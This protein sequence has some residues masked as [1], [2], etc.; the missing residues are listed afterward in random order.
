MWTDVLLTLA[1]FRLSLFLTTDRAPFA[2]M[3][4]LRGRVADMDMQSGEWVARNE[5]GEWLLCLWC[6]SVWIAVAA[7]LLSDRPLWYALAYSG[8]AILLNHVVNP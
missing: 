2:L 4:R 8:G 3:E 7:A 5:L 6:N 1:V